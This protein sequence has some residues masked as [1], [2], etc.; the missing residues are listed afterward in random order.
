MRGDGELLIDDTE[1]LL[2]PMPK[3]LLAF[4]DA[5]E[6][7]SDPRGEEVGVRLFL[8]NTFLIPPVGTGLA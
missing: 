7:A 6:L 2:L 4:S 8:G 5:T 1:L 3:A